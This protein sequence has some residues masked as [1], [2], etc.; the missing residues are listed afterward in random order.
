MSNAMILWIIIASAL[1]LIG[2]ITFTG[3][4]SMLNWDFTR[5]STVKYET[6]SHDVTEEFKGI[7]I[8]TET[9]DIEFVPSD[10]SGVSVLC[11]EEENM[12]HS[13]A[14]R[15]ETLVIDILDERKWYNF[16]GINFRSPKI[17]I[18]IPKG[19]YG[20][21]SIRSD[22]GDVTIPKE[23][24][25]QNIDI[26]QSTGD[27]TNYASV[28]EALKIKTST[29]MIH[30]EN[31]SAGSL[32]LSTSTGNI[33]LTNVTASGDITANLSTGKTT[34]TNVTCQKLT[35]KA[36]TGNISLINVIATESFYIERSTG[37]VKLDASDAAEIFINTDT[38]DVK[39]SLLSD[40]VF[41]TE[42]DTGSISVPN[43]VTGGRCEIKT[44]TGD[45]KITV[46]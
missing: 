15:D 43:S 13:V 44:D 30:S 17:T 37:D 34:L 22:T 32:E 26:A 28:S 31:I 2:G 1:I 11:Y 4:M 45:I 23:L 39:G 14:V 5:L 41:I 29:G 21:L 9:A 36:D 7:S 16:I 33:I 10:A 6:N 40:K 46:N 24:E 8:N 19:D 27:V 38:G 25:F 35:S 42:T 12:K 3:V 20:T 18:T